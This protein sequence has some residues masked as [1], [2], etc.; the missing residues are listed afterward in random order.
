MRRLRYL[1]RKEF[2][3]IFRDPTVIRLI[4]FAPLFQLVMF[5]YAASNDVRNVPLAIVDA[6]RSADSRLL[7]EEITRSHYFTLVPCRPDPRELERLLLSGRAQIGVYIPLD[8][9][10]ILER[11][12]TPQVGVFVDGTDSN[13]AA[14]AGSYLGG[15]LRERGARF[16]ERAA[17]RAGRFGVSLP[18]VVSEP[19]PWYNVN[20][21]SINYMIPGVF[22]MILLVL[23]VNLACLAIVRERETGTL[24]QLV[25]T[26]VRTS[27]LLA[28]KTLPFALF[29]MFEASIIFI[30]ATGWF[31]VPFRGSLA[32]L[33]GMALVFLL[34]SL[35]LGLVISAI[36]RTQQE[37][38]LT[39]FM[40]LM[41][42]V[43]LSGFMFPIENMPV[44]VQYL[45]YFIPFRY[46]LQIVR[47]VFLR[48]VGVE[49]LW[50]QMLALTLFGVATF[51]AGALA[52][53][54]RL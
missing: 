39:A 31:H 4:I 46:F 33:F 35:G 2:I 21:D 52:F 7:T 38:Q 29:A 54:K 8:F 41:P 5:G 43:L 24:E 18:Q 32:I 53:H 47:G 45:T 49:V 36:T 28:G 40:V 26:P 16:A 20:L 22:G 48:G 30:L 44:A 11:G 37:A 27:E 50:P 19:R 10:R 17:R 14:V 12:E 23:T 13:N 9:H 15:I 1:L 34:H 3:Q 6:D 51:V 42:S 25:V